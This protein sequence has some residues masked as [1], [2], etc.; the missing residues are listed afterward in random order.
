MV[1]WWSRG[2]AAFAID[3]KNSSHVIGL[4]GN[5]EAKSDADGL[6]IST[7]KAASWSQTQ[8]ISQATSSLLG[9]AVVIDSSSYDSHRGWSLI[10]YFSSA[11]N[12]LWKT[13]D[14]GYTWNKIQDN[15]NNTILA[16]N[17]G[18]STLLVGSMDP[19]TPGVYRSDDG[20]ETFSRTFTSA[21][22][23][24][25]MPHRDPTHASTAYISTASDL[26]MSRDDG[27][28]W[29]KLPAQGVGRDMTLE[30][31][32]VAPSD[33]NYMAVWYHGKDYDYQHFYS[34]DGGQ[35]FNLSTWNNTYAFMPNNARNARFAYHPYNPALVWNVGGD[36]ITQSSNYGAVY[37][38]AS[39][40]YN[41]VM[42]GSAFAFSQNDPDLAYFAFQDYSGAVTADRGETWTYMNVEGK[43]WGGMGYGGY[44]ANGSTFVTGASPSWVGPRSLMTSHDSGVTW[45]NTTLIYEGPDVSYGDPSNSAIIFASNW[46]SDDGGVTWTNMTGCAAVLTHAS[47]NGTATL[48]GISRDTKSIVTSTNGGQDWVTLLNTN[49][50]GIH[51]VAVGPD[52]EPLLVVVH[53][54]LR[55]CSNREGYWQCDAVEAPL[56]QYNATRFTTVAVDPRNASL[57]YAGQTRDMYAS[58][59]PVLRST[60]GGLTWHNLLVTT[61][62]VGDELQGP[63]E[64]KWIRVHPTKGEVWVGTGCFGIWR[65]LSV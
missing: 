54:D 51:D 65:W 21:V 17:P 30:R 1:G 56:D 52:F 37:N 43:H 8:N 5:S 2:G 48:F 29:T 6:Y 49:T 20:G 47:I 46:R 19:L 55:R 4:G 24:L 58:D 23:G 60:D 25:D 50:T 64:V 59:H 22:Y 34:R 41:A 3:P 35:T 38:W 27:Q 11:T 40:G 33:G 14:G 53:D 39:N 16:V 15:F 63:H 28:T 57:V 45:H 42:T 31:I 62:L 13:T 12:G 10:A 36:W 32:T 18:V 44:A 7:D 26:Y 61:P 9:A